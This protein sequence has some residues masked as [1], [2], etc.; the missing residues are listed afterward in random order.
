MLGLWPIK[1]D[2]EG[3]WTAKNLSE[4]QETGMLPRSEC[5]GEK[6][7]VKGK[8]EGYVL[9]P[10]FQLFLLILLGAIY[11][12]TLVVATVHF[13]SGS[14]AT[15]VLIPIL[16]LFAFAFSKLGKPEAAHVLISFMLLEFLVAEVV[17]VVYSLAKGIDLK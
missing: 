16:L 3:G 1:S 8:V 17:V 7:E 2:R 4:S 12:F 6:V 13:C 11:T 15:P 9:N 10:A 5:R 14:W